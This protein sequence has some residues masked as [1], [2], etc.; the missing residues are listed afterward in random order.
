MLPASPSNYAE[1]CWNSRNKRVLTGLPKSSYGC[2]YHNFR[3]MHKR[4]G[5]LA[6]RTVGNLRY[7]ERRREQEHVIPTAMPRKYPRSTVKKILRAHNPDKRLTNDVDLMVD[8]C[9]FYLWGLTHQDIDCPR[10]VYLDLLVFLERLATQAATE[11]KQNDEKTLMPRHIQ[12]VLPVTSTLP[13]FCH[14]FW[15]FININRKCYKSSRA[16]PEILLY[17]SFVLYN[18]NLI[19]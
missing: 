18:I 6:L 4:S 11:A 3:T 1:L 8:P 15:S 2:T 19:R 5:I 12:S 13:S 7:R 10:Q 14:A 9:I 16:N 17:V